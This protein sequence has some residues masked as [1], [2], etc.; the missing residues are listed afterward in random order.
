MQQHLVRYGSKFLG[1]EALRQMLLCSTS[2]PQSIKMGSMQTL[3]L[4]PK[5]H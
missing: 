4:T 5:L 3:W 2:A 1:E